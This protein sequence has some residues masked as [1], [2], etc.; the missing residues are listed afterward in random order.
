MQNGLRFCTKRHENHQSVTESRLTDDRTRTA[1]THLHHYHTIHSH[2]HSLSL[3]PPLASPSYTHT[4]HHRPLPPSSPSATSPITAAS[5][6][7]Y[8]RYHS[9]SSLPISPHTRH[10]HY[11]YLQCPPRPHTFVPIHT[12]P[13][14]PAHMHH[15][16]LIPPPIHTSLTHSTSL[17]DHHNHNRLITSRHTHACHFPLFPRPKASP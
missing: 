7:H 13:S 17:S 2:L 3:T 14:P 10:H 11:L 6:S 9:L 16:H 1:T 4:L 15:L 12:T 8:H 5:H